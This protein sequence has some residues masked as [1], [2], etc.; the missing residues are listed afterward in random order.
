MN[1][2]VFLLLLILLP[3]ADILGQSQS[4]KKIIDCAELYYGTNNLIINGR[5]YAPGHPKA[6][7]H[8]YFQTDE[9]KPGKIYINGNAYPAEGLK[10]NLYTL[11]LIIKYQ[12]PNGTTQNV[13]LS[14]LLVDSFRVEEYL[15]VNRKLIFPEEE[16]PGYLE[17]I[18]DDQLSFFRSQKKVFGAL[19]SSSPYGR[20]SSPRDVFYLLMDGKDHVITKNS[21]FIACF[22][23]HK[24]EIKKYMKSH[25]MKWNKM[26]NAQFTELLNYCH[27]QI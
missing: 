1:H 18:Y 23:D 3:L 12:R 25:S 5:P 17:N 6:D 11:Q 4:V 24:A 19:T 2:C 20:F 22:P 15:F 13:I 10:Y 26:T 8:P 16:S 21:E 14:D 7:G 9:W 27:D